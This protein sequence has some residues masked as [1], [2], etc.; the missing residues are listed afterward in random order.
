MNQYPPRFFLSSLTPLGFVSRLPLLTD[1]MQFSE[2]WLIKGGTRAKR[3]ALIARIA[4]AAEENGRRVSRVLDPLIPSLLEA[5]LWDGVSVVDSAGPRPIE[6]QYPGVVERVVWIGD[7]WEEE[8]LA[9]MRDELIAVPQRRDRLLEQARRYFAACAAL[10]EDRFRMAGEA[11]D[12]DKIERQA[13]R[14]AAQQLARRRIQPEETVCLLSTGD[15]S[16]GPVADAMASLEQVVLLEDETGPSAAH[17][18][19]ALRRRGIRQSQRMLCGYSPLAPYER[20]EQLI[21]PDLSLGFFTVNERLPA[22]ENPG[23]VINARRFTDR[24]LLSPCKSRMAFHR[25]AEKQMTLLGRQ[26]L[27][28]AR[29][30]CARLEQLYAEAFY[31]ETFERICSRLIREIVTC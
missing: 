8:T 26:T 19:A 13:D 28:A 25:K 16:C 21:F 4:D 14:I 7:C 1:P 20:L 10:R 9:A 12:F 23:R 2:V 11:I 15:G 6:P 27:S 29:E 22:A 30:E 24:A 31:P 18:L 17:L 5:A 3:S